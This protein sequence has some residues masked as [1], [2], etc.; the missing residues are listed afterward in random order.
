MWFLIHSFI[1]TDSTN[2]LFKGQV[3][4]SSG[5]G[6]AHEAFSIQQT[7]QEIVCVQEPTHHPQVNMSFGLSNT[8]SKAFMISTLN[9][10]S[11]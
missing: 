11:G 8:L 10:F 3:Y 9:W 1:S 5:A 7:C 2:L 6:T 4:L